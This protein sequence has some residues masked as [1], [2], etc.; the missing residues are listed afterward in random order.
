MTTAMWHFISEQISSA[1]D[2]PFICQHQKKATG[3]DTHQSFV[4]RDERHRFFVKTHPLDERR[5]LKCE[6]DGLRALASVNGVQ[7]PSVITCGELSAEGQ[8]IEYLVLSHLRFRDKQ[9]AQDYYALGE[10]VARLHSAGG[11]HGYG[12]ETN[13]FIGGSVQVNG[14]YSNWA[15]FFAEQRIG[16]MLE[17]LSQKGQTLTNNDQLVETVRATLKGHQPTPALLHGDLWRG[18][19]GVTCHGPAIY[20]PAVYVGDNEADIAMTSLFGGFPTSF[21]DG[22]EAHCPL[23]PDYAVRKPIYQLYH[24]LNHGLLFGGGYISQAQSIINHIP[25]HH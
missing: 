3:G 16:S 1:L 5:P 21:Y 22:Y 2:M 19:A 12:W 8:Q 18:N 4:I 25:S 17:R 15:D 6:A 14:W 9:S 20:D 24:I 10:M 23:A 7:V 13:N 11:Y